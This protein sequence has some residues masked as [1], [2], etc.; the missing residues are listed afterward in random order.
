MTQFPGVKSIHSSWGESSEYSDLVLDLQVQK[1]SE[2][3][4]SLRLF[5]HLLGSVC[6]CKDGWGGNKL[7]F[8]A[9]DK[10]ESYCFDMMIFSNDGAIL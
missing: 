3:S 4:G 2:I 6:I 8:K 1:P 5:I 7:T 9:L 10:R